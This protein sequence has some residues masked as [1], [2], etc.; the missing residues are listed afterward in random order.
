MTLVF[1]AID[2]HEFPTPARTPVRPHPHAD[3]V[4]RAPSPALPA[5]ALDPQ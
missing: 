1:H 4:E 5:S 2:G 3:V